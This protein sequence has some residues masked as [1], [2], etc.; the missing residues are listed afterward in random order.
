MRSISVFIR[1][2][3]PGFCP[4]SYCHP[5]NEPDAGR[6][7]DPTPL[8]DQRSLERYLRFSPPKTRV[9]LGCPGSGR[10]G[11]RTCGCNISVGSS[12]GNSLAFWAPR[13]SFTSQSTNNL[14]HSSCAFP[15]CQGSRHLCPSRFHYCR[16]GSR[17]IGKPVI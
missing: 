10:Y 3:L 1:F 14:R 16:S 15:G 8:L 12:A 5:A 4:R 9:G 7:T 17:T 2:L 13:Q 6:F 11:F